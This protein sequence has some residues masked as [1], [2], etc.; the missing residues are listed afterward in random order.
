MGREMRIILSH[1][2]SLYLI[3]T[4]HGAAVAILIYTMIV[5]IIED[6]LRDRRK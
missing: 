3:G 5:D 4:L 6:W 1:D 2:W